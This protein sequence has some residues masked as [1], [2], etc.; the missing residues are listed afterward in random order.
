MK[1]C[2]ET[3]TGACGISVLYEFGHGIEVSNIRIGGGTGL[4]CAGFIDGDEKSDKVFKEMEKRGP[5]LFKSPVRKNLNSQNMF[6]FAVFDWS[7]GEDG[8]YGFNY[9]DRID[10]EEF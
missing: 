1:V 7:N 9:Q 10:D 8:T 6:Y 2:E 5:L 3:I 4:V